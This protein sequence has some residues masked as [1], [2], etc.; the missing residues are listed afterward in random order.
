MLERTMSNPAQIAGP[1]DPA[2][3]GE[4]IPDAL[5]RFFDQEDRARNFIQGKVRFGLLQSY[6]D[7]EGWRRDELEGRV[8]FC[9]NQKAPAIIID[10]ATRQVVGRTDSD[11]NI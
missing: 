9:W 6:R 1:P 10:K 4:E 8:S 3:K 5:L 2:Q 7:V 11:Q